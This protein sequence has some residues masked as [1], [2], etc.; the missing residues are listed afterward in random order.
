MC[1]TIQAYLSGLKGKR[2]AVI[3]IGI[4]NTP[5]I[6]LLLGAGISVTACDK[7]SREAF[8][9]LAEELE[10]LGAQLRLGEDYLEGL[11][12]DVIF[13]TPGM[14]PDVPQLAEAVR[15]GS[16]LTSEME[17][18][19][20]VCPC[21][22]I[23]VT[24]SAGKTTTKE[25]I[26]QVVSAGY[27]TLKTEGNLNNEIGLPKTL[28][29]LDRSH[30]AAVIEMGMEGLGEIATLAA[31]AQPQ[32][33]VITNVGVSHIERLG[34]RENILK[35]KME[36]ADA[37]P[38]GAPLLLCGD[39]DLLSGVQMPRLR[40]TFFGIENPGCAVLAEEIFEQAGETRFILRHPDGR[41]PVHLPCMGRHNV[42]NALA[43]FAVGRELG[44]SPEDCAQALA[45]YRPSGM[46][47]KVVD[48]NGVTVVE[49][50]YNASP[51]SMRAALSTLGRW[52]GA[53]RRIAVLADMLEL[54]E[55]SR[56]SHIEAGQ[57]AA[58]QGID[59][60]LAY[61]EQ[62]RYYVEGAFGVDARWFETKDALCK[63]LEQESIPGSVIWVKASR[64]M[65][66]E[67]VLEQFY[68]RTS[69][70]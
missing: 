32:I 22:I 6:R 42:L 4:S 17:V 30:Q 61:G 3:G 12:Q 7:R 33:G 46:R 38:D 55:I 2:V 40:V 54:G 18:F 63:A 9:G 62:G 48:W 28:F 53:S 35:A 56:M 31:V 21:P 5:L 41:I 70:P 47:Q 23:A 24:G 65:K 52:E 34:S 36:L 27:K 66:L 50:C 8:S 29:G 45:G 16:T 57:C 25:M 60:L 67:E 11:D 59:L 39:N 44:I 51:D 15:Q 13:R 68:S 10:G 58:E 49:D 20:Q 43:A 14:R 69:N 26:A 37:L 64:G 1:S 19:F